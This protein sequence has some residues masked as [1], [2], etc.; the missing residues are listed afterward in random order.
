M[1]EPNL[2]NTEDIV[3]YHWHDSPQWRMKPGYIH[4]KANYKLIVDNLLDFTHLAWVHPTTLGTES[5]AALKPSIE[6]DTD[7]IG[8]LNISRW[9]L[10]DEMPNLHS[11]I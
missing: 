4:Y 3:D 5:A 7:G 1:G 8:T 9:Y 6:R 2:A 11:Q 10:N